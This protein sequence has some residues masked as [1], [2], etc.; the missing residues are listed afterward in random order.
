MMSLFGVLPN[1]VLKAINRKVVRE[2]ERLLDAGDSDA[3]SGDEDL[4]DDEAQVC[5]CLCAWLYL[6]SHF[7]CRVLALVM[8]CVI[9]LNL[10]PVKMRSIPPLWPCGYRGVPKFWT[11]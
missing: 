9:W 6:S 5:V 1:S 3:G 2:H 7:R 10:S 8:G 4:S 11:H